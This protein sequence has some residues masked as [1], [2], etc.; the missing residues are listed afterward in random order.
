MPRILVNADWWNNISPRFRYS[1]PQ[2]DYSRMHDRLRLL[3]LQS[4]CPHST[5]DP[6]TI[7]VSD[8]LV[9]S[10]GYFARDAARSIGFQVE[11]ENQ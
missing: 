5:E 3:L 9:G 7:V 2:S 11:I 1:E 4:V 10:I 8:T 6:I